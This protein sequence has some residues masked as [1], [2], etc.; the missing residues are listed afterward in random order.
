[1]KD[2]SI[3]NKLIV[4]F[5]IIL[6]LM[7]LSIAMSL[8][9]ISSLSM[10]L[11]LY[12][13]STVPNANYLWSIKRDMASIQRNLLGA[14]ISDNA[15]GI[16]EKLDAAQADATN[17]RNSLDMY[18][19][20]QSNDRLHEEI[21]Q[22][23]TLV[24]DSGKVR[25]QM[26]DLLAANSAYN[27]TKVKDLFVDQCAPSHA[28]IEK[29][30]DD[31]SVV[32]QKSEDKQKLDGQNAASL[33]WTELIIIAVL[34]L[35]ITVSV[36]IFIRRSI[37]NPVS[38]IERVYEQMSKGNLRQEIKYDS[39]DELGKMAK[40]MKTTN[41][42]LAAYVQDISI[43][44][45]QLAQG[46]MRITVDLDYAGDFMAIKQAIMN[47]VS[48]LN[49]TMQ[50]IQVASE[51]VT[52]GAS[53]VASGA[54]ALAAGSTE[55]ASSVEVLSAAISKISGQAEENAI[56]VKAATK[57][58]EHAVQ[59]VKDASEHM[60]QLTAAMAN[61]GDSSEQISNITKVIEDIAFQ[62]NILAL[63]AAI[64]AARA[65]NAG[66]G[67]AV[68]ADEVRNL[69]AKS[70]EA[71]KKTAELI[72]R[73]AATVDEGTEVA[74]K[75]AL[76]LNSVEEKANL[77]NDSILKIDHASIQQTAAIEQVK[78]GLNQVSS[79]IQTNAATAE[80]NSATSEEMAAQAAT[81]SEEV[82]KFQL[83]TSY[84]R[85]GIS[86]ISLLERPQTA[87]KAI[88]HTTKAGFGKY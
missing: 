11:E 85:D 53:Q 5:G 1:M 61:I 84:E 62:T 13:N 39:K 54:Q 78:I 42:M 29:L 46:D 50:T 51:Q 17:I 73:S 38:E 18:E 65:G 9:N 7:V 49:H 70:A 64:E 71:A 24:E 23:R 86:T 57:Y 59:N 87:S 26:A 16:K 19:E 79:V 3:S 83:D 28:K 33:A 12:G 27:L 43:K 4:G 67:F 22:I 40:S 48:A 15:A 25:L 8:G 34:S 80:E 41:A 20:N 55:Q 2:L 72:R 56:S 75:T 36:V 60:K 14:Y 76:I 30:I 35:L 10:Q 31:L 66:K 44:L 77:V 21:K 74:A 81:L 63:N 32:A 6:V 58:V 82:E 68:V 52:T 45:A 47:T 37:M 88:Q 69:A